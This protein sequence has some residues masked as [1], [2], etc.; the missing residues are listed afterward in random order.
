MAARCVA[1]GRRYETMGNGGMHLLM[2]GVDVALD[3]GVHQK[4]VM[5]VLVLMVRIMRR[6]TVSRTPGMTWS[7]RGFEVVMLLFLLLLTLF[8]LQ[9]DACGI[10]S[11]VAT[12]GGRECCCGWCCFCFT[13]TAVIAGGWRQE[14]AGGRHVNGRYGRGYVVDGPRIFISFLIVVIINVQIFIRCRYILIYW[15]FLFF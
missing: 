14:P 8:L 1:S 3:C 5:L 11:L 10:R 15:T 6:G 12:T 2:I 4:E 13:A 7:W 9:I